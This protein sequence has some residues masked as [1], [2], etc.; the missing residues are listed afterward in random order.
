MKILLIHKFHYML[1]GTE[2]FHYNL[3]EA[4]TAA[5]H[6]VIFFSMYDERNIPCAQD[7]YFVSNVDY[8]D[9]NLSTC[10]PIKVL[11]FIWISPVFHLYPPPLFSSLSQL[12]R[13]IWFISCVQKY[14]S[15][16]IATLFPIKTFSGSLGRILGCQK[17]FS[18]KDP[19]TFIFFKNAA[20]WKPLCI[21]KHPNFENIFFIIF[22]C[23]FF[24]K[25]IWNI[26]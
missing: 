6:E 19:N 9:P 4:L 7:K 25:L 2:T 18:P 26:F 16:A 12:L 13:T 5:G 21:K 8:N 20:L 3:A 11:S 1:G 14:T 22:N 17:H 10:A 24:E 15:V 23:S